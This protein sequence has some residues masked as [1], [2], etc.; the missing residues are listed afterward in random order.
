[1]LRESGPYN[2]DRPPKFSMGLP[3]QV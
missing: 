1:M 3:Y 2:Q